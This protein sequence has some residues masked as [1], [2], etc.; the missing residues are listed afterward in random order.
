MNLAGNYYGFY[1]N[2]VVYG[3]RLAPGASVYING[4]INLKYQSITSKEK[5]PTK[6]FIRFFKTYKHVVNYDPVLIS[7]LYRL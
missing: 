7:S 3:L 6:I 1:S 5:N 2:L 4:I